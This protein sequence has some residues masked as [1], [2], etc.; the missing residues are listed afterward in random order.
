[1]NKENQRLQNQADFLKGS[2]GGG[3]A[4]QQAEGLRRDLDELTLH[5]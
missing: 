4:E 2:G 5:N 3:R 1:V